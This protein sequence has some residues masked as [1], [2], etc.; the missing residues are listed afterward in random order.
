MEDWSMRIK[1]QDYIEERKEVMLSKPVFKG[2]RS[3]SMPLPPVADNTAAMAASVPRT[4][5]RGQNRH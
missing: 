3:R 5:W 2:T 1:W 4:T